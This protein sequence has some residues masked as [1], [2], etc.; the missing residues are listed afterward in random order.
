MSKNQT[1]EQS[2]I[3]HPYIMHYF[4]NY[5]GTTYY[6]KIRDKGVFKVVIMR[7]EKMYYIYRIMASGMPE[8]IQNVRMT[9]D[10][11]DFVNKM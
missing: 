9:S 4:D 6:F 11:L 10:V 3:Q 1:Y 5:M 7:G 2:F 8:F